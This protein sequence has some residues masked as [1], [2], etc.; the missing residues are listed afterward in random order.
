MPDFTQFFG[1]PSPGP[2]RADA[3]VLPL[4]IEKTV[5]YGVGAASGPQAIIAATLQVEPFDEET[6][7][8]FAESPRLHVLPPVAADGSLEDCLARIQDRVRSLRGKFLV[9]LGGEHSVTYGVIHGLVDDPAEVTIVQIDAHGDLADTLADRRWSHGTVMR[10]LWE[11]G[12]RLMQ[13]GI[14]SMTRSEY[15]VATAGPR[16]VT[17]FAHRLESQWSDVLD[18]LRRLEG[19]VYLTIDVDG[20][21]PSIIPSTGTPQPG[22]LSWR[23]TMEILR[24]LMGESRCELIGADVVEFVASPVPPG[25]D[26]AA[27]RLTTKLLAWWWRGRLQSSNVP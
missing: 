10:R 21:D 26:P 14:R 15:E 25:C 6:L 8:D 11:K 19:K 3:L 2:E 7:V 27:A 12:C 20:L 22:G 16:I 23:Q 17:F 5:S 24:V 18:A 1:L 4:P 9:A 13:I